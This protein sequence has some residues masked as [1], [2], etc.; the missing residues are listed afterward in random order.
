MQKNVIIGI[1]GAFAV[2]LAG[3]LYYVFSAPTTQNNLSDITQQQN[4]E[5]INTSM[6]LQTAN[7][8]GNLASATTSNQNTNTKVNPMK[9]TYKV[10]LTTNKGNIILELN[11]KIAPKTVENFVKLA[12]SGFYNG[13][14]FHRV[15]KDFMI[16]AGDPLSKD[17][18][19]MAA[20]G[21]GGMSFEG[22]K[23]QDE[24]TGSQNLGYSRGTL[25]MAN[26][27]PNT[28]G[29]QFFI[30]HKD[31]QLPPLY[32]VFGKVISG[33]ET[34]DAIANVKTGQ[35]DRPIDPVI[36]TKVVVK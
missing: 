14:K 9:E 15:I 1:V 28:N 8:N 29:S 4:Q 5:V 2:V 35:A 3:L 21:T 24:L 32:S 33:I 17:D 7:E 19:K 36:I 10:T 20:W 11:S 12:N 23:F 18:G 16:Q 31:M 13:V 22:G 30:M 26:S 25:A 6:Q 34:V 27:G